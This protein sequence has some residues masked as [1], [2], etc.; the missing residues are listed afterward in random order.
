MKSI[1]DTFSRT[2]PAALG[3][4]EADFTDSSVVDELERSGFIEGLYAGTT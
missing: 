4:K 2:Y 1:R 3:L